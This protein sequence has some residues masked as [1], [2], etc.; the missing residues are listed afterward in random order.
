MTSK[1]GRSEAGM[2]CEKCGLQCSARGAF[3]ILKPSGFTLI[4][5][6]VVIAI[7]AIL[8]GLLLPALNRA[9]EKANTTVCRSNLKQFGL[10]LQ[11]YL[12]D[13][14]AYPSAP[15]G[16]L[17][18]PYIGEKDI[19]EDPT[20]MVGVMT[21]FVAQGP[22]NSV[23]NCPA[24]VRLPAFHQNPSLFNGAFQSYGYNIDGVALLN[25]TNV[26]YSGLGLGGNAVTQSPAPAIREAVVLRPADMIAFGDSQLEWDNS[27]GKP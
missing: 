26:I 20:P 7:I 23:Y 5:L 13:F 21:N 2:R 19:V 18:V 16:V 6:L 4:E 11:G 1:L 25:N 8:A 22:V 3:R 9:K 14:Q 10:A 27:G 15:P 24:Y 17:L 12:G